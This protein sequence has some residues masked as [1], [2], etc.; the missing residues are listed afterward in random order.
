MGRHVE[1]ASAGTQEA[2]RRLQSG[3]LVVNVCAALINLARLLMDW[4][5]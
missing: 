2:A 1:K 5:S 4:F 3:G